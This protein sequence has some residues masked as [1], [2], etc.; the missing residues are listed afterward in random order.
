MVFQSSFMVFGWF[1]WFFKL[2]SWFLMVFGWFP[3]IFKVTSWF[4]ILLLVNVPEMQ[5]RSSGNTKMQ[6]NKSFNSVVQPTSTS[7]S[8]NISSAFAI[9]AGGCAHSCH[10]V[11]NL[12]HHRQELSQLPGQRQPHT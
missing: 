12:D 3:W 6:K 11:L 2:V 7:T 10:G 1:P 9:D 4:F 8:T 5:K